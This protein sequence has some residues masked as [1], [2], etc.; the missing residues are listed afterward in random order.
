ME[1]RQAPTPPEIN[2]FGVW[3]RF[4]WVV[5][6]AGVLGFVWQQFSLHNA[7]RNWGARDTWSSLSSEGSD[8]FEDAIYTHSDLR[9]HPEIL[10]EDVHG[11]ASLL[12]FTRDLM[13]TTRVGEWD[14][15]DWRVSVSRNRNLRSKRRT[16]KD[17][18]PSVVVRV[19]RGAARGGFRDY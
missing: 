17:L 6:P 19:S 13:W 11:G 18:R 12:L 5:D 8:A 10:R 16:G 1:G 2:A 7:F 4:G 3:S 14:C 9:G 15:A